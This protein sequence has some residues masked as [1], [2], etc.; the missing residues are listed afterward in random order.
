M[1]SGS[2]NDVFDFDIVLNETESTHD[3]DVFTISLS[4]STDDLSDILTITGDYD[5]NPVIDMST[6]STITLPDYD[7]N[8]ITI[9]RSGGETIKVAETLEKI[10]AKLDA[11]ADRVN[12]VIDTLKENPEL[13]HSLD[14]LPTLEELIQQKEI[15]HT[16]KESGKVDLD[17]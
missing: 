4:D 2:N 14:M 3:D 1:N 12:T 15:I 10:N 6:Y 11:L 5:Y 8:D 13:T 17:D 9:H 7:P 16:I